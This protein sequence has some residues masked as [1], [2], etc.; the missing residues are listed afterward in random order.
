[1][2]VL[3]YIS[4]EIVIKESTKT[5]VARQTGVGG[6]ERKRRKERRRGEGEEK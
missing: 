5:L 1:M 6:T 2:F 4:C 3:Q